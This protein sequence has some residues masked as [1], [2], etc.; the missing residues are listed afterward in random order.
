MSGYS[1]DLRAR[2][3]KAH[4]EEGQSH[5]EVVR[6]FG[7]SRWSVRRYLKRSAAGSL[8]PTPHPGRK[9]RLDNAG[10]E[11][12]RKQV[13]T[14]HDWSLAQHA[15]AISAATGVTLKKS[16]VGNYLKR[17]GISYKK[18]LPRE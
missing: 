1:L 7:V 14:H 18:K 11:I 13:E 4:L 16:S 12:L 10:C 5:S 6:R 3:V 15:E 2:I 17:L 9:Q 8:A